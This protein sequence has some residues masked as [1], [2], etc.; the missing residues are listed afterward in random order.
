M[1]VQNPVQDT[2]RF[3]IPATLPAI[4]L[5]LAVNAH[6]QA[7]GHVRGRVFDP[8]G[9]AR[10][11]VTIG[12][13]VSSRELTAVTDDT[14]GYGFD[15]VPAGTAELTFRLLRPVNADVVLTLSLSVDVMVTGARTFRNVADVEE[16]V[17]NLV[18]IAASASKAL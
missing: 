13:V 18:G 14:G 7:T 8:T 3:R 4:L 11:G 12:L 16:P 5:F 15:A 10:P 1:L 9:A 17:P 6:A 2:M